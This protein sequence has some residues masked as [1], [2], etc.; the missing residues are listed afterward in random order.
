MARIKLPNGWKPRPD[1]I[2]LFNAIKPGGRA[3]MVAHRRWGKD[4]IALHATACNAMQRPGNYWHCLPEYSMSRKAIWEAVNPRSGKRRI[5]EAF[6]DEIRSSVR[7]QDMMIKFKN[8]STWQLIGSDN[9]NSLVGSPPVGIIFSEY[10]LA[11]PSAWGYMRPILAENNG[12]AGFISTP[13]GKNHL[14][15]LYKYGITDPAWFAQIVTA[16]TS[17]VFTAEQLA[18]EHAELIAEMGP[19]EGEAFFRQEYYCSFE[20]AVCGSYYSA[21]ME[22]AEQDGHCCNVPYDPNIPVITAWDLGVGDATGIWFLQLV[23]AEVRVIDYYEASGEGLQYYAKYLASKPY[24]YS[25]HI[26]PHDIR[27]RELGSGKSRLETA[28]GLGIKPITICPSLPVDD[29]IQAVRSILPR[30]Y[31]D[32]KKTSQGYEALKS[33]RKEYDDKRK[34]YKAKPYHDWTSHASD[35]FR[36]FAVGHKAKPKVVPVSNFMQKF[37]FAGRW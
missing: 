27:V 32:K 24:V 36:M 4:D 30:C 16:A 7:S 20:G 22:I 28:E 29:G 23:G 33:Y 15:D 11:N 6:P 25:E 2:D 21:I 17:G 3:V 9:Y 26:M 19:E 31:F 34:E 12:Y 10:A 1:Q 37:N 35:A 5:D 8:G 14:H 13:R 18:Q